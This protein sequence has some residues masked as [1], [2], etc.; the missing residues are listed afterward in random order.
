MALKDY[1]I[2]KA[3]SNSDSLMSTDGWAIKYINI[4]RARSVV[5]AF[6]EDTSG[7]V[8]INEVNHFTQSRPTN[9]RCDL[10]PQRTKYTRS[11]MTQPPPLDRVLG[12]R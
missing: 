9:W 5:E 2:V 3:A 1:Y 7:F 8:T 4:G 10:S 11:S 6:D 12:N